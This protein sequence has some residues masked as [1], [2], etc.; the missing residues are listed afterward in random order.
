[1]GMYIDVVCMCLYVSVLSFLSCQS[2][3]L[4][5]GLPDNCILAMS[6]CIEYVLREFVCG[7]TVCLYV[8]VCMDVVFANLH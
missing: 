4:F 1:M 8:G 7:S 2:I 5:C 6:L 3:C